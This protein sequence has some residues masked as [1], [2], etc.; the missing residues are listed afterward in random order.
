MLT[1]E[2]RALRR[3]GIGSSDIAALADLDPRRG[4]VDVWLDKLGLLEP[5]EETTAQWCG[6]R[7]E[8]PI[9]QMYAERVGGAVSLHKPMVASRHRSIAIAL[10]TPDRFACKGPAPLVEIKDVGAHML[11]GWD[12]TPPTDKVLQVQWQLE[13]CDLDRAHLAALLGG[14]DFRIYAIERDRTLAADLLAI[15][16][17]FWREHVLAKRPPEGDGFTARRVARAR[18]PKGGGGM[19]QATPEAE[20]IRDQIRRCDRAEAKIAQ[21]R[22]TL[23][24]QAMQMIGDADGIEKCFTWRASSKGPPRWKEIA[25]AAGATAE[26]IDQHRGTPGRRF[27][28]KG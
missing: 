28:L 13:V 12:E 16:E 26:L 19:L 25:E 24:A 22:A 15:A 18:W 2:Q 27:L 1:E 14:T 3:T 10:A 9:A 8:E 6:D 7:L 4:P 20:R 23:E 5:S 17:W 21:K 11:H